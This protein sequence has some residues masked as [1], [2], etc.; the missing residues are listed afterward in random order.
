MRSGAFEVGRVSVSQFAPTETTLKEPGLVACSVVSPAHPD[1]RFIASSK[2][3]LKLF[4]NA[5]PLVVTASL[6]RYGR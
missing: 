4:I 5:F 6:G 1:L 2:N 3:R